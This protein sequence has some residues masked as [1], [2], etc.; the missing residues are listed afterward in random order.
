MNEGFG[1]KWIDKILGKVDKDQ[2]VANAGKVLGIGNDGQ[3]VP[4]EQSGGST[5]TPWTE[6]L[7]KPQ[8]INKFDS[9]EIHVGD[10]VK[11]TLHYNICSGDTKSYLEPISADSSLKRAVI[12]P[13]LT[14]QSS[15]FVFTI[16]A[17]SNNSIYLTYSNV[18]LNNNKAIEVASSEGSSNTTSIEVIEQIILKDIR[19][20]ASG[21]I[22]VTTSTNLYALRSDTVIGELVYRGPEAN[23]TESS[24]SFSITHLS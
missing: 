16:L 19:I 21:S 14:S 23:T 11:L 13:T 18:Y 9:G 8:F 3:V 17:I 12:N 4:V 1:K 5:F 15:S 2:G 6:S 20:T 24:W 10:I 7:S 22:Y